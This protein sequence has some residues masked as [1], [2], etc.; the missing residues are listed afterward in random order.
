MTVK[1]RLLYRCLSVLFLVATLSGMT[2]D[3]SWGRNTG[4]ITGG[5]G[6]LITRSENSASP[7][8]KRILVQARKMSIETEEIIQGSCWDFINAVFKRARFTGKKKR[9]SI[10]NSRQSGPYANSNAI[11]SGD[12]LYYVN[13]SYGK[14][15]HSGI[16]VGW[17]NK[18][19]NS[20]L[21]FSYGG[22]ERNEPARYREY[23]LSSV[24][25]ILRPVDPSSPSRSLAQAK[26]TPV[27]MNK[28]PARREPSRPS[29][30]TVASAAPSSPAGAAQTPP[31]SPALA[32]KIP[33]AYYRSLMQGDPGA[34]ASLFMPH[35]DLIVRNRKNRGP[36]AIESRLRSLGFAESGAQADWKQELL[37]PERQYV[38]IECVSA[39]TQ[40][41]RRGSSH[42]RTERARFLLEAAGQEWRIL[43]LVLD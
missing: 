1:T 42:T 20:A 17:I 11:Q 37:Y 35:A 3:A 40:R 34:A 15:P 26:L 14:M 27:A 24:Y 22:E 30:W 32:A 2:A 21:I 41:S 43:Q 6:R 8:G 19:A 16:F 10:F 18:R 39:W 9:K 23:D 25:S 29:S 33:A 7:E 13:Y 5:Y 38:R 4:W 28:P 31:L 12:W 36:A